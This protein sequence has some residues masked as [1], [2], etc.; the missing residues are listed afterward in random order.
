MAQTGP[1]M[2]E[3][4]DVD[5]RAD[6]LAREEEERREKEER[7]RKRRERRE[8]KRAAMAHALELQAN[9]EDEFEGFQ[10]RPCSPHLPA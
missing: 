4:H 9:G 5:R 7:R 10:V 6:A 2:G 3:Q 8:L 1:Q